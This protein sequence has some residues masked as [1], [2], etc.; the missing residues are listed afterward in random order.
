MSASSTLAVLSALRR[1]V[2][3]LPVVTLLATPAFSQ[4][5]VTS[6]TL[7]DPYQR[8]S[9][10]H[11]TVTSCRM[12]ETAT[13]SVVGPGWVLSPFTLPVPAT[14]EISLQALSNGD[15]DFVG[16]AFSHRSP[17]E[18]LQLDW[19]RATQ[20]FNW[21]DPVA[22]NDDTAEAGL[23]LKRIAGSFTRDG[24]WGGTDGLGVSTLAGPTGTGWAP[25]AIY[26]L[27]L[28]LTP[29]RVVARLDGVQVFD[30]SHPSVTEGRIG[31]Y[32]FSQDDAVFSNV[33]IL[34]AAPRNYC[35]AG[36]S[37]AGCVPSIGA[38]GSAS[39]AASSGFLLTVTGLEAQRQGLFF[40][41][42]SGASISPWGPTSTSFLCVKSPTQ[43]LSLQSSGGTSGNCDGSFAQDWRAFIAANP[44]ALG[45]PLFP[46]LSACAQAWY[47]DPA[48]AKTTSLTD[49]LEFV[50][51]P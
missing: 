38:T 17:T 50:V 3:L 18:F 46:G 23:K 35:T 32:S 26:T 10:N 2:G 8:W 11:P 16:V 22:V 41:G 9:K 30:V 37:S 1:G 43:R 5:H 4:L 24:L 33:K 39:V 13:S 47:R 15:D 42:L 49:A 21:G 20:T 48:A 12:D 7:E 44:G 34:S 27:R 31:F 14:V 29:G 19:K 45:T 36:T 6:W 28:E 40:Y 25:N 51:L